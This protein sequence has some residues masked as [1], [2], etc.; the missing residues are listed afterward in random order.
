[1]RMPKAKAVLLV[2]LCGAAITAQRQ[3]NGPAPGVLVPVGSHSLHLR[4]VGPGAQ[5][6]TVILEAG[7]GHTRRFGHEYRIFWLHACEPAPMTARVWA[8]ANPVLRLAP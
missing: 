5:H 2:V 4:C 3:P 1:M 8:G 7:G 6:P